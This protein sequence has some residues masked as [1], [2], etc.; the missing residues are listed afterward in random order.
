LTVVTVL[1][2]SVV[3]A[4][5]VQAQRR[6]PVSGGDALLGKPAQARSEL[7]PTG[8]VLVQGEIWD[9]ELRNAQGPAPHGAPLVV[10]GREGF[11]LFVEPAPKP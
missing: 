7:N 1:F 6:R 4:K 3:L 11:R 10:T 2:F 9:A 8:K 5:I